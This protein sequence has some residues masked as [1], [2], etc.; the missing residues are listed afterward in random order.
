MLILFL[1]IDLQNILLWR[2]LQNYQQI[3]MNLLCNMCQKLRNMFL[4][5]V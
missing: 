4:K 1:L 2:H 3:L 5:V